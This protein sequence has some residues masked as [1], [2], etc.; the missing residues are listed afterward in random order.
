MARLVAY[1]D[2]CRLRLT[3]QLPNRDVMPGALI[4]R[5]HSFHCA[6][7]PGA[8]WIFEVGFGELV[9]EV[10][11]RLKA[12]GSVFLRKPLFNAVSTRAHLIFESLH[13]AETV[14]ESIENRSAF[15]AISQIFH[16]RSRRSCQLPR[17]SCSIARK[18]YSSH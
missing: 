2:I 15:V 12:V 9:V 13:L 10:A 8:P 1:P 18:V 7:K 6:C 14:P 4:M 17:S 16:F 11:K 3:K 5:E